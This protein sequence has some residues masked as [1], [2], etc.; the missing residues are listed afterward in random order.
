MRE[1]HL[2][3][4]DPMAPR[5]AADA[6]AGR[7]DYHD[8]QTWQL[9]LGKPDE[10]AI[11]LETRYGGRVGLARLLPIWHIG[12]RQVYETQGYHR[13]PVLTAFAPDYLR[14][15]ADLTIAINLTLE[16]WVMESRAVGGR[17]TCRNTGSQPQNVRLDMI[18]QAVR[19]NESL[20]MYFLTLQN[21]Q[22]ALQ[23][24]KLRHLAPILLVEGATAESS[25]KARLG[26]VLALEPGA[27]V[28]VRWVIAGLPERDAGLLLAHEWLSQPDWDASIAAV[29]QR[30][31]M[32][33]HIETG[34]SGWD[35]ALAW[36]QQLALR[37]F[38]S[39]TGNLPHPSFVE[40]RKPNQGFAAGGAHSGGFRASWGG[41]TVPDA[42]LIAPTVALA[43]PELAKGI[44]R[45]FLAVQRDDGW[46]DAKPG[47]DSQRANVLAPPLLATLAYTVYHYTGDKAFLGEC[48]DG[49]LAF[50]DR[51]FQKDVDRDRDGL[52]EWSDPEQGAFGD[53]P[54]FAQ[55]RR[56]GAGVDVTTVE[57]PD[58]AAY[59][60]REASTLIRIA[61]LL[62]RDDVEAEITPQYEALQAHL[63]AMWD[64][65]AG[66]F[67]YRDRDTHGIPAG[68]LVY[69]GKG[70]QPFRGKTVL[71]TPSRLI[72]RISGGLSRKPNLSCT[73]E[74]VDE[75]GK[76]THE[77]IPAEAFDW[78]R[79]MG[80]ATTGKVWREVHN[81]TFHGL[82][83][84]YKIEVSL[85]D[86]SRHD[87]ALLIPLWSGALSDEQVERT[88][89]LLT[90]PDRYWRA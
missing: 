68:E 58:L 31:S 67:H 25:T 59:L 50:F 44:V 9:R 79:G 43:A 24:G 65:E 30:A 81:L 49:L 13:P 52:P 61:G 53:G 18:A 70:D 40:S 33:P 8:D 11:S 86:L 14:L 28:T 76:S 7:T 35:E 82:S 83:R 74:G 12:R 26:R 87:Q 51:W 39:A 29:E 16:Y 1:W 84:V 45:N 34:R 38:L 85:V 37:C 3:A 27:E 88:V 60:V 57:A 46:I 63:N 48:L 55:G 41:Q 22:V 6:R 69:D 64:G 2:T 73:I 42:L 75:G 71:P 66:V 90:D 4:A 10:P 54:T 20:Q 80:S 19:E 77:D 62:D 23:M 47:L 56:W 78:Y 36:S 15:E 72:L 32:L 21:G 17:F 89:A 5:I